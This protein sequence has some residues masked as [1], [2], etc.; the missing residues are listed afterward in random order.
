MSLYAKL[1]EIV[2]HYKSDIIF[3]RDFVNSTD[4]SLDFSKIMK[5]HKDA[6]TKEDLAAMRAVGQ[7]LAEVPPKPNKGWK[8][9]G[10]VETTARANE[11]ILAAVRRLKNREFFSEMALAYILTF[12]ESFVK[13]YLQEVFT[14]R[15]ELLRS[16]KSLSY[17]DVLE[18]RSII[19]LRRRLAKNETDNI[20][21]G[22]IDDLDIYSRN[23]FNISIDKELFWPQLKEA[24]YRRNL[25]IHNRGIVNDVYRRKI[26]LHQ[27]ESSKLQTDSQY[28]NTIINAIIGFMDWMHQSIANKLKLRREERRR[29]ITHVPE[30]IGD[31][32]K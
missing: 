7:L 6:L 11:I 23:K 3:I 24:S 19:S 18:F 16:K 25:I 15:S 5:K 22:S 26:G 20:G 4:D 17:E 31:G 27:A 13:D 8:R 14:S 21:Y 2:K 29:A 9:H 1:N 12:Q 28:V 10:T 30:E 32:K